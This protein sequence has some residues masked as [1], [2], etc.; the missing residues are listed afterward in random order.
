[1]QLNS[2]QD[3]ENSLLPIYFWGQRYLLMPGFVHTFS[4]LPVPIYELVFNPDLLYI[5]PYRSLPSWF[6]SP[7]A[8]L[9]QHFLF[10]CIN[11]LSV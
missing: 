3:L 10:A 4:G 1:M 9:V 8:I 5:F 6:H 2:F 7:T 11:L